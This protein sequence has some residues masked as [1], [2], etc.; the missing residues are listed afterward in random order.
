MNKF[1]T[2]AAFSVLGL[3][4]LLT[5]Q[6]SH[7]YYASTPIVNKYSSTVSTS[8]KE[9]GSG[10]PIIFSGTV[11]PYEQGR[12]LSVIIRDTASNIVLMK[13]VPVNADGTYSYS[14]QDT[15]NWKKGNYNVAAQYGY[16]EVDIGTTAFSFDPSIKAEPAP[17]APVPAPAPEVKTDAKPPVKS[18]AKSDKKPIKETKKT[19]PKKKIIKD[20]KKKT[21]KPKPKVTKRSA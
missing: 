7:A 2:I 17:V 21:T 16:S 5:P 6:T 18:D 4:L 20:V 19:E 8:K 1:A 11:K 10:E 12:E 15:T 13:T 9:Y 14:V 3:A